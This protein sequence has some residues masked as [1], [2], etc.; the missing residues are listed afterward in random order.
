MSQE[1]FYKHKYKSRELFEQFHYDLATTELE[2]ALRIYVENEYDFGFPC[3][4]EN[5][6]I[7]FN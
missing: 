1:M 7:S 6:H 5:L 4:L 2:D 3:V